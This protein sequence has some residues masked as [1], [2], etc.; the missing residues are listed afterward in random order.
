MGLHR[1]AMALAVGRLEERS[2]TLSSAGM[3]PAFHYDAAAARVREISLPGTPLGTRSEFPYTEAR[4]ELA[5]GDALLLLSDG[6]PELPD[7]TGEPFG[8]ER[9]RDQFGAAAESS[10]CEIVAELRQAA[11]LWSG[12]DAPTD[13]LTFLVL[14]AERV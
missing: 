12:C 10:A 14:K 13:D 5:P 7:S 2:L 3:P 11:T 1:M 8:Y 9:L 6:L 4:I